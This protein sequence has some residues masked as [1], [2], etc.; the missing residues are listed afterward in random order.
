MKIALDPLMLSQ[1]P[2]D[3]VCRAAA[4]AGFGYL[5]LSPRDDFFPS[6]RQPR[7]DPADVRSLYQALRTYHLELASLWTV[8]RWADADQELRRL[9]V[10][11]WQRVIEV[12]IDLGCHNLNSEL[13]G[14]PAAPDAS[15][16]AFLQSMDELIP[17]LE[18]E[19]VTMSIEAHPG[20]FIEDNSSAVD[21]LRS[22]QTPHI[23]Y[24]FCAPHTFHLGP[25]VEAMLRYAAPILAHVHL[26][27]TLDHTKPLRYILN[28][29]SP[30][31]RIHQH[32]NIGEGEINWPLFFQ[33]LHDIG[34]EGILTSAVFAWQ[35][36]AVESCAFMAREI[37]RYVERYWRD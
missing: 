14:D 22:L 16:A 28:P 29:P 18:R 9:A 6:R 7:V 25:D 13:S 33:T 35:D 10:E 4:E 19:G 21:L 12:A 27:D 1:L 26:A 2:L 37:A 15:R 36:R 30:S 31:I 24:L 8:Y 5:E 34:F 11:Y 3:A 17:L 32:L 20:D 23:R